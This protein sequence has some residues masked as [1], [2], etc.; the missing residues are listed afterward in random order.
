MLGEVNRNRY[1]GH[2]DGTFR[3][4]RLGRSVEP[5]SLIVREESILSCEAVGQATQA[6]RRWP[7]YLETEHEGAGWVRSFM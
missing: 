4:R 1:R 5:Q 2:R 3:S 7:E 6:V